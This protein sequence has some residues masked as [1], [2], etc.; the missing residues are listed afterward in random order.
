LASLLAGG[1]VAG[2]V[3]LAWLC[4]VFGLALGLEADGVVVAV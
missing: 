3:F 2:A 4:L 1:F